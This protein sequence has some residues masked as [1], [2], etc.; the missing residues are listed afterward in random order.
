MKL[1]CTFHVNDDGTTEVRWKNNDVITGP[2]EAHF[3]NLLRAYVSYALLFASEMGG[4][5]QAHRI[6]QANI[7]E[8]RRMAE[9]S[10]H[11]F[12]SA[13]EPHPETT[14]PQEAESHSGSQPASVE[15]EAATDT[16]LDLE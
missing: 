12:E 8:F 9:A 15:T 5:E 10:T 1:R 11:T 6:M 16:G 14:T 2:T 7:M 3:C 4:L 13:T